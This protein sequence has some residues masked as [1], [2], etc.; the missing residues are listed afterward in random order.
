MKNHFLFL[1][2]LVF[3]I[4]LSNTS[5]QEKVLRPDAPTALNAQYDES[6]YIIPSTQVTSDEFSGV[7]FV[8]IEGTEASLINKSWAGMF[9]VASIRPPDPHGAAGPSGIIA[10][11]NLRT[12]YYNKNG[13]LIWGPTAMGGA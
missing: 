10:V 9:Q 12:A 6:D 7:K 8:N 1:L 4:S 13:T 2:F 5:A 11:V 3:L